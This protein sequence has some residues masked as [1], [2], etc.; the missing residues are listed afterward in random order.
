VL[1]THPALAEA[2]AFYRREGW[3]AI[4]RY[5]DNSYAGHWFE[6]RLAPGG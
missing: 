2:I 1:D 4:P 6:K 3:G 5:N